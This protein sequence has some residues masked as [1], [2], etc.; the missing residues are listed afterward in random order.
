MLFK[1]INLTDYGLS[2]GI[3]KKEHFYFILFFER[4]FAKATKFT[5]EARTHAHCSVSFRIDFEIQLIT[6]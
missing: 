2:S 1:Y 6:S 5:T 3:V 4:Q